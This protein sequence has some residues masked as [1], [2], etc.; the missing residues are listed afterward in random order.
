VTHKR[1]YVLVWQ[2]AKFRGTRKKIIPPASLSMGRRE[3]RRGGVHVCHG[4]RAR[5]NEENDLVK[6]EGCPNAVGKGD[7]KKRGKNLKLKGCILDRLTRVRLGKHKLGAFKGK[8][9][10]VCIN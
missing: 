6:G 8:K 9:K 5:G 7:I 10:N 1:S 4:N 3:I 2:Q